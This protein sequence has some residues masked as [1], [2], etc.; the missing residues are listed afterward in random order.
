M[1][2][3]RDVASLDWFVSTIRSFLVKIS[4]LLSEMRLADKLLWSAIYCLKERTGRI[5]S[6][7]LK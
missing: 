2:I 4:P 1:F 5:K 3:V 6:F 7:R